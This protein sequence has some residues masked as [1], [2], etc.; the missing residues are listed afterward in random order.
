M[1][2]IRTLTVRR[3]PIAVF[4]LFW[5]S[6]ST[7]MLRALCGSNLSLR[8][9]RFCRGTCRAFHTYPRILN[10]ALS[11]TGQPTL[12][13]LPEPRGPITIMPTINSVPESP[14]G[15]FDL[16]AWVKLKYTDVTVSKWQN[17]DSGLT[18]VHLDYNGT[19]HPPYYIP[20]SHFGPIFLRSTF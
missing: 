13:T 3:F 12:S 14:I 11:A 18:V 6:V 10:P 2:R 17:R 16:K 8:Q 19:C 9:S 7:L 5:A 20:T 1:A 4:V 15:S